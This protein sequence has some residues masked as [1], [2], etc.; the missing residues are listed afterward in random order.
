MKTTS[1]YFIGI[2]LHSNNLFAAVVDANGKR[3]EHRRIA[4]DLY[5][6]DKFLDPMRSRIKAIAV[7]STFNW[8]WL[9]DGIQAMGFKVQLANP[10]RIE[11]YSGIKHADDKH[12]AYWLAELLRQ[13]ILETGFIC[14]SDWR[15][16][17]DLLRRRQLLMRHRTS[18][19]LSLRS[20][21]MRHFGFCELSSEDLKKA[22]VETVT[23]LFDHP[24][25]KM[26]AD[27]EKIA[28]DVLTT[29]ITRIEHQVLPR[30]RE[31]PGFERLLAIPGIGPILAM[32]I[33][34]EV[35]DIVRFPTPEDFAS[36]CR[37]VPARRLSNSKKKGE[38]N[39]R[40]GNRYL[41]WAFIEAANFLCRFDPRAKRWH[42]RKAAKTLKALATKAL[43]CKL[44]KAVWYVLTQDTAFDA[45]R[46]F[47]PQG[48]P[49]ATPVR[50]TSGNQR[51]GLNHESVH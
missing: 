34:M 17:R 13:G 33:A 14:P 27:T 1:D 6:V 24:S 12:D 42:D 16:T 38:N 8:Y 49:R 18:L 20:L 51:K 45:D 2:D 9:V 47:G 22:S 44:A 5:A 35:I 29:Q 46:L 7:E 30:A 11:Q 36:Y 37:M 3:I 43:G 32:T 25:D 10:A 15:S 39:R 41:C 26:M 40:C 31:L 48:S 19:L 21:Q 4:C 50:A 28:L 23:A